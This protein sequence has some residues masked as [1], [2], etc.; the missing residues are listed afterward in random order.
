MIIKIKFTPRD[1][2]RKND[3]EYSIRCVRAVLDS[4]GLSHFY[5]QVLGKIDLSNKYYNL[6]EIAKRLANN[7]LLLELGLKDCLQIYLKNIAK[8]YDCQKQS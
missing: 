3:F 5:Y 4:F 8:K 1:Y 6:V 2:L 7:N